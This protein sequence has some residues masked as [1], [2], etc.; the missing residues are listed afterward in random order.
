MANEFMLPDPA[1]AARSRVLFDLMTKAHG[2][3]WKEPFEMEIVLGSKEAEPATPRELLLPLMRDLATAI[4]FFHGAAVSLDVKAMKARPV[5]G[6]PTAYVLFD[7]WKLTIG[8][9]GYQAW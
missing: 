7:G 5:R 8:S 9:L 4:E 2:R 1:E 3:H 6:E